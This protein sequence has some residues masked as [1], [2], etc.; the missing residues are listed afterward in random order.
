LSEEGKTFVV[1]FEMLHVN[2]LD[3][4]AQATPAMV[5]DRLLLRTEMKLYSFR[6]KGCGVDL[7]LTEMPAPGARRPSR[8]SVV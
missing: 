1:A 2:E 6:G 5:G 8:T 3:E 4:M 7:A